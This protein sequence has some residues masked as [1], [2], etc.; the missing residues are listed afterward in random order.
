MM[1]MMMMMDCD[2]TDVFAVS[3]CCSIKEN[4]TV[5]FELMIT[6]IEFNYATILCLDILIV[7]EN[8][9]QRCEFVFV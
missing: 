9:V 6:S 7:D 2:R 3:L 8:R 1:M 5:W 4:K